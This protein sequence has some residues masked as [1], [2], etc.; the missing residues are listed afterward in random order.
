MTGLTPQDAP[1][2]AIGTAVGVSY[3]NNN[4]VAEITGGAIT[5]QSLFVD[6]D[7]GHTDPA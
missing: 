5:A 1:Q 4:N 6:A 3:F 2:K 7:M